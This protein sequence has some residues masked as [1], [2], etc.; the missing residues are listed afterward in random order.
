MRL[1]LAV[2]ALALAVLAA[3]RP[4]LRRRFADRLDADLARLVA[5]HMRG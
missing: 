2:A 4:S 1:T 5:R 3:R